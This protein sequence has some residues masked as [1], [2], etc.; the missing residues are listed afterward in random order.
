[1]FNLEFFKFACAKRVLQQLFGVDNNDILRPLSL[2][3]FRA[4]LVPEGQLDL[5]VLREKL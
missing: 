4:T 2:F 3:F 1:M 5:M